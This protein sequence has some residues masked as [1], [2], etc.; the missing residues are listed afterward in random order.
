MGLSKRCSE[1]TVGIIIMNIN[2]YEKNLQSIFEKLDSLVSISY[3][4]SHVFKDRIFQGYDG[5]AIDVD[6]VSIWIRDAGNSAE[7]GWTKDMFEKFVRKKDDETVHRWLYY[8]DCDMLVCALCD[9]LKMISSLLREFYKYF[10]CESPYKMVDFENVTIGV[11][12]LDTI[13]FACVNSVFIC[14]ASSFDLLTKIYIELRDYKKVDFSKYPS[15]N[16]RKVLFKKME[17]DSAIVSDTIFEK[18]E[19]ITATL[20]IR[21][22]IVHNGSFDFMQMVYDCND[23]PNGHS[24][25]TILFPDME[26][27]LFVTSKNRRNFYSQSNRLNILLPKLIKDVLDVMEKTINK[28]VI[29]YK[30]E[31]E[32]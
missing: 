21:D 17:K 7:C 26:N 4:L 2:S 3:E 31:N 11:S 14:L 9:R 30:L 12:S 32:D 19:C 22:R 25:T 1:I 8:Y 28:L 15:M 5:S 29:A 24:E 10:P 27:G 20:S 16:S 23:G 6:M 13:S 18:P